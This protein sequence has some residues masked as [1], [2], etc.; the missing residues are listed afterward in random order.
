MR[1]ARESLFSRGRTLLANAPHDAS[2]LL[3]DGADQIVTRRRNC[4]APIAAVDEVLTIAFL[5]RPVNV[6]V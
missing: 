3:I 4:A 5:L 6:T 2:D 1:Y